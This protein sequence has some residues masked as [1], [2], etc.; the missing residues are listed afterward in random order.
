MNNTERFFWYPSYST[1]ITE[2]ELRADY[3]ELRA[4]DYD[5]R[6]TYNSF[7]QYVQ[8]CCG[9][10]GD[11]EQLHKGPAQFDADNG[12]DVG[13][14]RKFLALLKAI[15]DSDKLGRNI[16]VTVDGYTLQAYDDAALL[17]GLIDAVDAF[18]DNI[19]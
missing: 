14:V 2:K 5:F 8:A 17:Q 12:D 4:T 11:L 13:A 9:P 1:I 15:R 16:T 18:A 3:E 7:E 6:H 19:D 10:N